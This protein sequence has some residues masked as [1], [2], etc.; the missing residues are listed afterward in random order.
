M[1]LVRSYAVDHFLE[2]DDCGNGSLVEPF[3]SKRVRRRIAQLISDADDLLATFESLPCT[4]AHHDPQWGN[5]FAAT[6]A[7]WGIDQRRAA[8]YDQASTAAY[9]SGLRDYGWVGEVD[10]VKFARAA[11]AALNAGTWLT[12]EVSWLCPEM[13]DRFGQDEARQLQSSLR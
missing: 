12:M 3:L 7:S 1:A 11:A 5:L 13:A 6:P 2:H 4:L 9:I 10:S 8:E